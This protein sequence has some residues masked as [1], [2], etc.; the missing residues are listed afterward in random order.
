MPNTIK[1]AQTTSVAGLGVWTHTVAT[2]QMYFASAQCLEN[3]PSGI[4]LTIA[5]TGSTSVSVSVASPAAAQ[6]AIN[7][8]K[9]FNCVSG[10]VITFTIASSLDIDNQLNTV[11]TLL[12]ITQ[13]QS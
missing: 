7:L 5:Q 9:I 3:P 6:E 12:K 10:D 13:G 11:K 4:T 8:Q 1:G 2:T